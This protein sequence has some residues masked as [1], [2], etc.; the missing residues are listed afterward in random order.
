[1]STRITLLGILLVGGCAVD[2]GTGAASLYE[3]SSDAAPLGSYDSGSWQAVPAGC[4]DR[5]PESVTFEVADGAN[6]LLVAVDSQGH[7]V[8]ADTA[9]AIAAELWDEGRED[10]ADDF[11]AAVVVTFG[12]DL[13]DEAEEVD[14]D[15]SADD[16]SPQPSC[17]NPDASQQMR[18]G[19]TPDDGEAQPGDPSPQPS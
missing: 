11:N 12:A 1:M 3:V 19:M 2:V 14:F 4:E 15:P 18:R 9:A 8:C 10:E 5:L 6:G 16:P 7:A 13:E 17:P